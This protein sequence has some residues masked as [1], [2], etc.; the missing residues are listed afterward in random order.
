LKKSK[1]SASREEQHRPTHLKGTQMSQDITPTATYFTVIRATSI[2][3][4][5]EISGVDLM[6]FPIKTPVFDLKETAI[7]F[8]NR[9]N[10]H[11]QQ[12]GQIVSLLVSAPQLATA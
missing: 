4:I 10:D 5:R 12:T 11:Q 1:G 8:C 9:L 6:M 3:A 2:A 7:E